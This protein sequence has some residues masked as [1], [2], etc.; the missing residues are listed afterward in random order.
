V[1]HRINAVIERQR[2]SLDEK[3][4]AWGNAKDLSMSIEQMG[5]AILKF[6]FEVQ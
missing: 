5:V 6:I 2:R 3:V 1:A 4:L